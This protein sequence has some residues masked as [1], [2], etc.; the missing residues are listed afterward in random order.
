MSRSQTKKVMTI[1]SHMLPHFH[2]R[3][4]PHPKPVNCTTMAVTTTMIN[5]SA[6]PLH[7]PVVRRL[8]THNPAKLHWAIRCPSALSRKRTVRTWAMKRIR[9]AFLAQLKSNGFDRHGARSAATK[10]SGHDKSPS[11]LCGAL[12]IIARDSSVTASIEDIR[13]GCSLVLRKLITTQT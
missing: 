7:I 4:E 5:D 12:C 2:F 9:E 3:F 1:P 13:Q 8:K 6:H 11:Q 10:T